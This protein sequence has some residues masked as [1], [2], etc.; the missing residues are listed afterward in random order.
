MICGVDGCGGTP[1][2]GGADFQLPARVEGRVLGS[3]PTGTGSGRLVVQVVPLVLEVVP[4]V[5]EVVPLC[6]R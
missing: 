6:W 5:L 3:A 2:R 1:E 4:L